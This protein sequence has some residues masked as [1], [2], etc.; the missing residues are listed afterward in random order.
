MA[1]AWR[2][3]FGTFRRDSNEVLDTVAK[4]DRPMSAEDIRFALSMRNSKLSP[5]NRGSRDYLNAIIGELFES[6]I[7]W[8]KKE[9][10]PVDTIRRYYVKK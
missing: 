1:Y 6:G 2:K 8:E 10:T 5:N 3:F 9:Y 4:S 7:L